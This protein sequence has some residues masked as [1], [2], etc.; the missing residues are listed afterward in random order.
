VDLALGPAKAGAALRAHAAASPNFRGIRAALPEGEP[1][2]AW[3]AAFALLGDAEL[4]PP[5]GLLF[6]NYNH[7]ASRLPRLVRPAC[8]DSVGPAAS[9]SCP[10]AL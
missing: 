10:P 4:F 3:L 2:A 8:N 5:A 6:E 9:G 7:D 1:S